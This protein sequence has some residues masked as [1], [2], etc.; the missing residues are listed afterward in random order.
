MGLG[1]N[2]GVLGG[3]A[4]ESGN[5][6]RGR[7]SSEGGG[8]GFGQRAWGVRTGCLNE[9]RGQEVWHGSKGGEEPEKG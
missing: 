4:G 1:E 7:R 5:S 8:G 9:E 6:G 2:P 3:A